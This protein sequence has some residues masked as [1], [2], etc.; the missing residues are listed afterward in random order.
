VERETGFEPATFSLG[1]RRSSQLSY[2]RN[3]WPASVLADAIRLAKRSLGAP[4]NFQRKIS[5]RRTLPVYE[6]FHRVGAGVVFTRANELDG[7][8]LGQAHSLSLLH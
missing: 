4:L 3:T 5:A 8:P 7:V 6:H 1:T 2:T